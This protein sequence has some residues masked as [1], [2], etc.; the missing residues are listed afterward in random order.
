MANIICPDNRNY[1]EEISFSMCADARRIERLAND[2]SF[3]ERINGFQSFSIVTAQ[4]TCFIQEVDMDFS[5]TELLLL[6]S[7]KDTDTGEVN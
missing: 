4:L 3:N 2:I 5:I 7:F 6:Q 1:F